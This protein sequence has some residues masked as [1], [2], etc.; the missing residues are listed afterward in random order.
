[1][2]LSLKVSIPITHSHIT[3]PIIMI[4]ILMY[5]SLTVSIFTTHST[6]YG[7][8]TISRLVKIIRLFEEYRSLL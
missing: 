5:L 6:G 4:A 8:A 1:M 7:V 3:R 2:H